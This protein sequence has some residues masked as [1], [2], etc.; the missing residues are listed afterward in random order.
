MVDTIESL[1]T[2]RSFIGPDN[3]TTFYIASPTAEDIRGADWQYSRIYTKCLTEGIVT[4]AEMTDILKKRGITGSD[5]SVRL[6]ELQGN[7]NDCIIELNEAFSNEEKAELAVKVAE[8]REALVQWNQRLTGPMSNTCEQI[9]ED[10]RLEYITSCIITDSGENRVW[11]SHDDFLN[12]KDQSLSMKSR[13][14]VMLFLQG[15]DSDFFEKTPE[16]MAMKEIEIDI[17]K[18]VNDKMSAQDVIDVGEVE[19]GTDDKSESVTGTPEPEP[20]LEVKPS[21]KTAVDDKVKAKSATTGSS[22]KAT[23]KKK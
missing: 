14:E 7:L 18:E 23:K 8:A 1:E 13:Y 6:K 10:A 21:T 11:A 16:A 2:K 12:V 4:S 9:S 3:E 17:M 20:A 19:L 22:K 15:Y 5:Y